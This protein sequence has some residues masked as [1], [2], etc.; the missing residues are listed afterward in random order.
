[1]TLA[2]KV[3][4][5]KTDYD[6]VYS[7]GVDA[8]KAQGGSAPAWTQGAYNI[9][10]KS[11]DW[12]DEE[13]TIYIPTLSSLAE[14]FYIVRI[15]K[16][17]KLTIKSDTPITI[18]TN[19][20]FAPAADTPSVLETLVLDCDFS[21]CEYFDNWL[22]RQQKLKKIEGQPFNLSGATRLNGFT[23]YAYAIE[24]FRVVPNT[25]KISFDI[26]HCSKLDDGTIQSVIEGL[27]DLTGGTAQTLTLHADVIAKLTDDQL[28]VIAQKNWNVA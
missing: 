12:A 3:L 26:K 14:L 24:Y 17:K 9:R 2:E 4:R 6:E 27:A 23:S 28:T 16:I 25:V 20:F 19:A 1:M 13:T 8:G 10:F 7:A 21:Q 5:A 18:A 11:D 22:M 15:T